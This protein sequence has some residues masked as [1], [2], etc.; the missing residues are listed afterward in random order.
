METWEVG[1]SGLTTLSP[2]LLTT[3]VTHSSYCAGKVPTLK[4]KLQDSLKAVF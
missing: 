2:G 4:Q 1:E 3:H